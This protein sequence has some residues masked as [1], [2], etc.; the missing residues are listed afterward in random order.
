VE[1]KV[2]KKWRIKYKLSGEKAETEVEN[3]IQ[4]RRTEKAGSKL[5]NKAEKC[6]EHSEPKVEG[7][8]RN[9]TLGQPRNT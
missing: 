3:Q 1:K 2:G 6:G 9:L 4:T 7:E 5:K 8:V